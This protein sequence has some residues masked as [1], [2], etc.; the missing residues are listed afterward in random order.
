MSIRQRSLDCAAKLVAMQRLLPV[1]SHLRTHGMRHLADGAGPSRTRTHCSTPLISCKVTISIAIGL[2]PVFCLA[3]FS[4]RVLLLTK[5]AT[6]VCDIVL[7]Q[8]LE[9]RLLLRCATR[10]IMFSE[11][12]AQLQVEAPFKKMSGREA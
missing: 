2:V 4:S 5:D 6:S 7:H 9:Q 1:N 12:A 10:R 11:L 3:I 8:L